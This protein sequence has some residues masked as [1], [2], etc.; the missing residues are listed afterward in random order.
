MKI[1]TAAARDDSLSQ[2]FGSVATLQHG[3]DAQS[4]V[5]DAALYQSNERPR[6]RHLRAVN[7]ELVMTS[8]R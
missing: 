3:N 2:R 7:L 6:P 1:R 4:F 8:A 5:A